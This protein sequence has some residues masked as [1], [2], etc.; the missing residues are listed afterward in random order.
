MCLS[1]IFI[2]STFVLD[3]S[4]KVPQQIQSGRVSFRAPCRDYM[5]FNS[6]VSQKRRQNIERWNPRCKYC[7][8]LYRQA[9]C[10]PCSMSVVTHNP[11]PSCF[12]VIMDEDGPWSLRSLIKFIDGMS[13]RGQELS[14]GTK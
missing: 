4:D 3:V 8:Y 14:Y 6:R 7:M 11:M 5:C 2:G 12:K 1:N 9:Q 10:N 13:T